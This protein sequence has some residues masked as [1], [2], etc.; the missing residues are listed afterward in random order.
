MYTAHAILTTMAAGA[1]STQQFAATTAAV[2]QRLG[3]Q[4]YRL[5]YQ[6]QAT[7]TPCPWLQPDINDAVQHVHAE[8]YLDGIIVPIGFLCDHVEVL[9]DLDIQARDRAMACGMTSQRAAK[10]GTHRGFLSRLSA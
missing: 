9:Y 1:P 5:A 7:G 8:G 2:T 6:S 4:D 10:V 3:R